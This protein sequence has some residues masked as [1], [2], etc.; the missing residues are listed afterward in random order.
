MDNSTTFKGASKSIRNIMDYL[1]VRHFM[2]GVNVKWDFNIERVPCWGGLLKRMDQLLT[3]RWIALPL[4][5]HGC[6]TLMGTVVE[7][8]FTPRSGFLSTTAFFNLTSS[9]SL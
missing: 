7:R 8:R 6:Q 4:G 9:C 1:E 2:S 3:L 5:E